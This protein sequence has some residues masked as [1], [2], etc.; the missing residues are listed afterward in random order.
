[1]RSTRRVRY[2]METLVV[3]FDAIE[4]ELA[5]DLR[6]RR[7]VSCIVV[8]TDENVARLHGSKLMFIE[9]VCKG[10]VHC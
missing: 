8:I 9:S 10:E 4:T 2:G 3:G 6:Q 1:M 5:K 7:N